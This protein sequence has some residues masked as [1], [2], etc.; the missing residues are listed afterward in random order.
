[1]AH[2]TIEQQYAC[3]QLRI[4]Y[5]TEEDIW[6]EDTDREYAIVRIRWSAK[7]FGR[8]EAFVYPGGTLVMWKSLDA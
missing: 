2:R 7:G 5:G 4:L 6:I 8:P 1:M 3:D